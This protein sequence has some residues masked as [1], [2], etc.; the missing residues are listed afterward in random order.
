MIQLSDGA[1]SVWQRFLEYIKDTNPLDYEK[2]SHFV[3]IKLKRF[4]TDNFLIDYYQNVF[5]NVT[6]GKNK[7]KWHQMDKYLLIWC[8]AKLLQVQ[9]RTNLIPNEKDWDVLAEL[10]QVDSQLIKV[11]WISLLH[12]N[13]RIHSW[14]KKKIRSLKIQPH[15]FMLKIIGLS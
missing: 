11:K 12:S 4:P 1:S 7:K 13:L 8:V 3:K 9:H 2:I 6:N 10:L 14:T 15:N 5:S